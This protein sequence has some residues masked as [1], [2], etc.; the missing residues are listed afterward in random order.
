MPDDKDKNS[1]LSTAAGAFLG[2]A[3]GG[4]I[5]GAETR[6]EIQRQS[7]QIIGELGKLEQAR[8]ATEQQRLVLLGEQERRLRAEAAWQR[9][10]L[11]LERCNNNERFDYI[12]QNRKPEI[13]A[14]LVDFLIKNVSVPS[15]MAP[16]VAGLAQAQKK[17]VEHA[18][19]VEA[20]LTVP[21][22]Q[23]PF[24]L[25]CLG[26]LLASICL[27]AI[28]VALS[29]HGGK[30]LL[31]FVVVTLWVVAMLCWSWFRDTQEFT[32]P[33]GV[34]PAG[35]SLPL[36]PE[37]LEEFL[38]TAQTEHA[39]AAEAT[40]FWLGKTSAALEH[41]CR[42]LEDL[43]LAPERAALLRQG[44]E[45]AQAAYPPGVRCDISRIPDAGLFAKLAPALSEA[46]RKKLKALFGARAL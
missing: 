27:G 31:V 22:T 4:S 38:K 32:I 17:C 18:R 20:L 12:V 36:A 5:A 3:I 11:W 13:V 41:L 15:T 30:F 44:F 10:V 34:L 8:L 14:P 33:D 6:A 24:P 28:V 21:K 46:V 16:C 43:A 29:G 25:G 2:A 35:V 9:D 19:T 1:G 40:V 7:G 42:Q 37:Q 45:D 26:I 23:R 39:A